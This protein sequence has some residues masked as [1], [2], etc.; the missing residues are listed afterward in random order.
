MIEFAGQYLLAL[1]CRLRRGDVSRKALDAKEPSFGVELAFC[2][3][4]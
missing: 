1:F 4:L 2:R 3:F